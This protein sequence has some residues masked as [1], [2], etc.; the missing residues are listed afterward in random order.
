MFV[1][2]KVRPS[3]TFASKKKD[4]P[5]SCEPSSVSSGHTSKYYTKLKNMTDEKRSSLCEAEQF[6]KIDFSVQ[7]SKDK[8]AYCVDNFSSQ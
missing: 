2:G 6:Y 4:A 1:H 7:C 5:L 8:R 3:P